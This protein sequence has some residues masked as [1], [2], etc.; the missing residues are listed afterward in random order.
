MIL[1]RNNKTNRHLLHTYITHPS[2]FKASDFLPGMRG[3]KKRKEKKKKQ[4]R[5]QLHTQ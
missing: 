5:K 3:I 2:H 4:K 1:L